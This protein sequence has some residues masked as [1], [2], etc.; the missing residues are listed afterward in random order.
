MFLSYRYPIILGDRELGFLFE[1]PKDEELFFSENGSAAIVENNLIWKDGEVIGKYGY[2][3]S[4]TLEQ[5]IKV[6]KT[7]FKNKSKCE[8]DFFK[9]Y[10]IYPNERLL[11][12]IKSWE[13]EEKIRR[14]G[15]DIKEKNG[16]DK[17]VAFR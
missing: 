9:M 3:K 5:D 14:S 8:Q 16:I 12:D 11:N 6:Q 17:P 7:T 4:M 2:E 15:W 13:K 1:N 10:G